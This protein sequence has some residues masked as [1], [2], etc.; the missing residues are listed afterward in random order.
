M[1]TY[2]GLL[3]GVNVGGNHQVPMLELRA[4]FESLGY[5]DVRTFIQSG[6]IIFANDAAPVARDLE[7]EIEARFGIKINVVLR[8][9][10]DLR[11]VI[12]ENPFEAADPSKL[13]VGFMAK[14]PSKSDVDSLDHE[15][16]PVERFTVV[17]AN[18]YLLFPD[19]MARTKLPDYLHRQLKVPFTVR[20]WSTVNK[21]FELSEP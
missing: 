20:N 3:K 14:A 9:P 15:R 4:L 2:V 1:A 10:V 8:T 18:L 5:G 11:K 7:L 12:R 21:L 13:M 16:F 17:G 19:G 6:N